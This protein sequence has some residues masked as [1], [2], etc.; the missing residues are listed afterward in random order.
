MSPRPSVRTATNWRYSV[1]SWALCLC[2]SAA[3][4]CGANPVPPPNAANPPQAPAIAPDVAAKEA[5]DLAAE[6]DGIDA[7]QPDAK[8]PLIR[9][10]GEVL[11]NNPALEDD[12][13][14]SLRDQLKQADDILSDIKSQ[15]RNALKEINRQQ[16]TRRSTS[17]NIV[18][19]IIN[20][21]A[22][23]DLTSFG[24]AGVHTPHIDRLAAAGTRFTQFYAA[25][26]N[27]A[28]AHWSLA[29]GRRPDES[30]T[31]TN[32]A[33]RSATLMP[34]HITVAETLWQAGY[35]TG[36]FGDWGV[37]GPQ[38]PATPED[39]G[40]DEWLGTFES[41]DKSL[42]YPASVTFNGRPIKF[43]KN[44]NGQQGQLA[45]DFYI[46][47]AADFLG[48]TYRQHPVYLEVHFST[49]GVTASAAE[50]EPYAQQKWSDAAKSRAAGLTRID[51]DIGKLMQK[52][53]D[54]KQLGNTV[55]I[56]TSDVP[57]KPVFPPQV[58]ADKPP[59]NVRGNPGEL[60]EG[61][62]RIPLI[63]TGRGRVPAKHE[64][65]AVAAMWDL[66]PTIYQLV[67]AT[68]QPPRKA[69]QSL[70]PFV[71]PNAK[72]PTRFLFWERRHGTPEIAARWKNW[73]VVRPEGQSQFEL[74]DLEKDAGETRNVIDK[75]P[76][77]MAEINKRLAPPTE[78]AKR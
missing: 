16:R 76:E 6:K 26:P 71:A 14:N 40:F 5:P 29:T 45:Q 58:T 36:V 47:E 43:T 60:Y 66:A 22:L 77:V 62:L 72:L 46:A 49:D 39:Q 55:F 21:L 13:K 32:S 9:G 74:Y 70:L 4:G 75:H 41:A 78:Q 73:K 44:A 59:R 57:G 68:K 69:G 67:S 34:Q 38:G 12:A 11:N 35:T 3:V 37:L 10:I 19:L 25:S 8:N 63:I 30:S 64:C 53:A 56:I 33:V 51:R 18:L 54:I 42:P 20:D 52:L 23:T 48:R 27:K 28:D 2:V 61:G 7:D 65:Q 17:P 31:W 24:G 1:L 15:N 50:L